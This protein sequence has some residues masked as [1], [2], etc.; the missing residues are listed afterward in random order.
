MLSFL[1]LLGLSAFLGTDI[2]RKDKALAQKSYFNALWYSIT[3]TN[4]FTTSQRSSIFLS[5]ERS[6]LKFYWKT[7]FWLWLAWRQSGHQN[8][9][10]LLGTAVKSERWKTRTS[11]KSFFSLLTLSYRTLLSKF[12]L[13]TEIFLTVQVYHHMFKIYF[14]ISLFFFS[15]IQNYSSLRNQC[16]QCSKSHRFV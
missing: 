4:D 2:L 9:T 16:L 14:E 10:T 5:I 3:N 15:C 6:N 12:T 7:L 1:Y 11:G 8:E 13:K